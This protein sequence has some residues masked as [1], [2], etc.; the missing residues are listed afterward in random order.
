M[1]PF[2]SLRGYRLTWIPNDLIAG[3]MLAAIAI[4][5][6]LATA[7]LAGMPS[8]AGLYAFV[9]GS[10]AFAILGANRYLS[11]GA[12][13]TIAP[14]I[15]GGVVA[16]GPDSLTTYPVLVGATALLVG[17]LLLFAG[18]LRAGWIADL[19][20]MPVT[21]GFLAGIAVLI[22]VGQLP[23]ILGV[24]EGQGSLLARLLDLLHA[25]PQ[26]NAAAVA[27]GLSVLVLTLV[28]ERLS[29]RIPGA[30]IGLI[31]AGV[32][33]SVWHLKE[34]GVAVLGALPAGGPHLTLPFV[35]VH[36]IVRILPLALVVTL[37]CMVQTSVV[38]RSFPNDPDAPGD[39]S[40]DFAAV[41]AGSIVAAFLGS[42]AVDASPPRTAVVASA[43]GRS[44]LASVAA[45]AAV[46]LLV[47]L[48][49]RLATYVPLAA[50]GGVLIYV[51]LRIFRVGD[52][53]RIARLGNGEIMLVAVSALLVT[54][55]PI[56]QG[57]LL[58]IVLSLV[59]GIYVIARPPSTALLR[60]PNTT[61]WWPPIEGPGSGLDMPTERVPGVLVFAPA[62]PISFTNGH[63]IVG[64]LQA[65]V[66]AAPDP[67][68]LVVIEGSGIIDVDYTGAR[69]LCIEIAGLRERGVTVALARLS[70]PRARRTAA[71]TGLLDAFAAGHIFQSVQQAVDALGPQ[72]SAPSRADLR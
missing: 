36:D 6:Q 20:S 58:A 41:G 65:L 4:P 24:R 32:A 67:V 12:D 53:L 17:V 59:H 60:I 47:V 30:L 42:F 63:Y 51:A 8:Q 64:C 43:G 9:A 68:T 28:C 46:G 7:R 55:L 2:A 33:V 22:A 15:A 39:P 56:E 50:L 40:H 21:I 19:I 70:D 69:I 14:I 57:M 18:L 10:L 34:R 45:V 1:V 26:A 61:I 25:A 23:L 72:R 48:G 66:A 5:E 37:V 44:Q 29:P 62:A 35:D 52:M 49:A 16:I 11:V 38:L 3:I 54:V 13:S 31:G 71:R 27:I